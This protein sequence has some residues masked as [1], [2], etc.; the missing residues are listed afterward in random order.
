MKKSAAVVLAMIIPC[1]S[2]LGAAENEPGEANALVQRMMG[3]IEQKDYQGFIAHADDVFKASLTPAMFDGLC[4]LFRPR[5]EGGYAL[6]FLG[7]LVQQ[8]CRV[9]L[10][11]A[12]FKDGGDDTLVKLVLKSGKV[13]GFWLQ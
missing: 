7:E 10:W 4:N 11:K 6:T 12:Q 9:L 5:M 3:A 8:G 1:V 13:A 2:A